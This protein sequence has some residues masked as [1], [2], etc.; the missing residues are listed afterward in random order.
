MLVCSAACGADLLALDVAG[1][2]G[3]EREVVLP[4][5]SASFRE[6]SVVDRPGHWEELYDR[7]IEE[8]SR[9]EALVV[10]ERDGD[11]GKAFAAA[12]AEILRRAEHLAGAGGKEGGE[13]SDADSG[14]LVVAVWEGEPR[15]EGDMTLEMVQGAQARGFESV[16]VSTRY[17]D[18]KSAE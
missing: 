7:I 17:P 12:S 16:H 15:E 4:F 2:L 3:I 18:E 13:L 11:D 10:L 9:E 1:D 14:V 8:V 6:V 5:D